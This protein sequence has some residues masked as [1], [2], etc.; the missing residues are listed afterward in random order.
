LLNP[1]AGQP[2]GKSGLN[3]GEGNQQTNTIPNNFSSQHYLNNTIVKLRT[4]THPAYSESVVLLKRIKALNIPPLPP[5]VGTLL[6]PDE[7][8]YR[9]VMFD[10]YLIIN[11]HLLI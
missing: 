11:Y 7:R 8:K 5:D 4:T 2:R 6:Q 10:F 9:L 1:T 3:R